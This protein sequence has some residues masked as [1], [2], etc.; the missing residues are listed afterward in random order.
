MFFVKYAKTWGNFKKCGM[1]ILNANRS[2][3]II[4]GKGAC[5][6]NAKR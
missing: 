4:L 1:I 3:F 6:K 5:L 2:D